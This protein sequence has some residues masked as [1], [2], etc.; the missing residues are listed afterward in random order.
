MSDP[1][2]E[3]W[4]LIE[5]AQ[6]L[7]TQNY[8][9]QPIVLAPRRRL[10]GLGRRR[11]PL[12]RSHR[13]HRRH[14]ARPRAPRPG[15]RRRRAGDEA[16]PRLQP[17]LER[18]A[19]PAARDAIAERAHAMGALRVFFC[20]SGAEANEAAVK[21]AKRYQTTVKGQRRAHRGLSFEGSFHGRTDRHRRAHRAGEVSR[22]LRAA[23]RVGALRAV[24]RPTRTTS[25][26]STPSPTTTCAVII[27]PIQAEGGIRLP[28]PDFLQG[29][30]AEVHRHR[31]RPHLRRGADRRRPHRHLLRLRAGGRRRPTSCRSPRGSPAACPSAAWSRPSELAKGFAPGHARVDVRRQPARLR[32]GAAR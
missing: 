15:R 32:R 20:N 29:A 22:R 18:E 10:P 21:L 14:A 12:P 16:H 24:P 6:K 2:H 31:H 11:A 23:R 30:A 9:Q 28:P 3:Q 5:E 26:R 1:K 4:Q 13:R 8:R 19:D 7:F 25:A 27:E 17:L